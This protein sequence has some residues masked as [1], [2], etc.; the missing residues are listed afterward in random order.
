MSS[1]TRN[2]ALYLVGTLAN[3]AVPFLLLPILT[4][5]LSPAEFGLVVT[6][7]FVLGLLTAFVSLSLSGAVG[8]RYYKDEA[9]SVPEYVGTCIVIMALA[10]IL[11]MF[12]LLAFHETLSAT[13]QIP[14][15][16]LY[17]GLVS[18]LMA[19][20]ASVRLVLWQ[21]PGFP[22]PFILFQFGQVLLNAGLSVGL[23]VFLAMGAQG[24]LMGIAVG[25]IVSGLIAMYSLARSRLARP[26]FNRTHALSAL[27][28][29]L[30]LLPHMLAATA[31]T[32]AD[33]IILGQQVDLAGAGIYA[34][35]M[36]LALPVLML[37]DAINKA[38]AP[39]L[40]QQLRA[41][42]LGA[43]AALNLMLAAAFIFL[44]TMYFSTASWILP[45]MLGGS[46]AFAF[47]IIP[48]L[49]PGIAASCLYYMVGH[50]VVY[51][52]RTELLTVV[53]TT[54]AVIYVVVGWLAA[55]KFG[56]IG[57][58]AT[59]SATMI[60]QTVCLFFLGNK[61]TPLPWLSTKELRRGLSQLGWKLSP[62]LPG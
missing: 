6:F 39:W 42:N 14:A 15:V 35:G 61:L 9:S 40:Y 1:L 3:S 27:R 37:A 20:V 45:A 31:V 26:V 59:Y 7:Q 52:E 24:R 56:P 11:I 58:A 18:A 33:R 51:A 2:S 34:V 21:A 43:V 28:F 55:G 16:W 53:T 38:Y 30:P 25:A 22:V 57:L 47:E 32:Q 62:E 4:R 46:F 5:Y 49:A 50:P 48:W 19:G 13:L 41:Q 8:V 23:V 10:A 17:V 12:L 29:G 60:M 44:T 36:Q 54:G